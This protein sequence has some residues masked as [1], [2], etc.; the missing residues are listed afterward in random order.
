MTKKI[1]FVRIFASAPVGDSVA[2]L[3]RDTF[4]EYEVEILDISRL[5]K[6]RPELLLNNALHMTRSYG[7]DLARG[8]KKL[9]G[10][11]LATPYLF[12]RVKA[13]ITEHVAQDPEQYAFTFQLQSFF[14]A[15]TGLVPHFVY[16]DH[17]HLANLEYPDFDDRGLYSEAWLALERSIYGNATRVFTRSTNIA[18]SIVNQYGV[19]AEKVICVYAGVNVRVESGGLN[20]GRYDK[21][22]ILFVGIDWERKGGPDLIQAFRQVRELFPG[23]SLTIV[24]CSPE[25]K[26]P[27]CRVVGRIPVD[28]VHQYYEEASLFCLPTTLEPF[29]V[30]F[31]EA[32]AYGLP[33]VATRIGAIPDFVS[34]GHNGYLV[35]PRDV[36]A[37]TSALANL[38]DD[39]E[40]CRAFG[41][42]GRKL[43]AERYNWKNVGARIRQS[44]EESVTLP[45]VKTTIF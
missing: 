27:N 17:T 19:A 31:V 4:S 38:V 13:I 43:A 39:G 10:A 40:K 1:L 11:F 16:T 34:E 9:R 22:N 42:F 45:P 2:T 28:E 14:D 23:A 24:G 36:A 18:Q 44:I 29:G 12:K 5:I 7:L 30:V 21:G 33:I 8:H 26:L 15:S 6:D 25:I 37:L 32:M 20:P 3:L 41:Q 35:E